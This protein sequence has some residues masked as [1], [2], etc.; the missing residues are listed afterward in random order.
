MECPKRVFIN[1]FDISRN[2]FYFYQ[3]LQ[4]NDPFNF[5]ELSHQTFP[6]VNVSLSLGSSPVRRFVHF[7]NQS[8][9]LLLPFEV[10]E[11]FN[12]CTQIQKSKTFFLNGKSWYQY[13]N[14]DQNLSI[15]FPFLH[16]MSIFISFGLKFV[17][18][19]CFYMLV[20]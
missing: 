15:F 8:A 4:C 19:Y 2:Y 16:C 1:M 5:T 11:L 14:K 10:I 18:F 9:E 13:P 3:A 17:F 12:V 7:R 6:P 20:E